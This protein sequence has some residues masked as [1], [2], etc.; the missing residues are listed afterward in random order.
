MK[1]STYAAISAVVAFLYGLALL[2]I[3]IKFTGH[4]GITLDS[5]GAIMARFDGA[6]LCGWGIVFWL[7]RNISAAEKSWYGLLLSSL[8]FNIANAVI[9]AMSVTEGLGNSLGWS[10]VAVNLLFAFGSGYFAF[11]KSA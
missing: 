9:A 1:L 2:L 8:C 3:P 4:Y 10:T 6:S 7:N 5:A 11:R